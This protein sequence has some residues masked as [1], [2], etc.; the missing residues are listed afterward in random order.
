MGRAMG[1]S[2]KVLEVQEE[3]RVR[4]DSDSEI[5]SRVKNYHLES[6]GSDAEVDHPTLTYS[7]SDER[8]TSDHSAP[9]S[10]TSYKS[11]RPAVVV[12]RLRRP[13]QPGDEIKRPDDYLLYASPGGSVGPWKTRKRP[14]AREMEAESVR[15][16]EPV[17]QPA[18]LEGEG[19]ESGKDILRRLEDVIQEPAT[20]LTALPPIPAEGRQTATPAEDEVKPLDDFAPTMAPQTVARPR[21]TT[22]QKE[23]SSL[24]DNNLVYKMIQDENAKRHSAIS[25]GSVQARVV[26]PV[27]KQPKLRHTPK[28]DSLRGEVSLVGSSDS[29]HKLK[30]KWAMDHLGQSEA[31][32]ENASARRA[33]ARMEDK[34]A[35]HPPT[36]RAG[37]KRFSY[38]AMRDSAPRVTPA[39]ALGH[40][41]QLRRS[42]RHH[43]I[44]PT[45]RS[46]SDSARPL[47]MAT[48]GIAARAEGDAPSPR[49]RRCSAEH[50]LDRN[51]DVRRTSLRY[52][53][54]S[55]VSPA[56]P[57]PQRVA[58]EL[59]QVVSRGEEEGREEEGREEEVER[60]PRPPMAER[61]SRQD[62]RESSEVSF[63][64]TQHS[65]S[66]KSIDYRL[67]HPTITPMSQMSGTAMSEAELCEAKGI[68]FFPHNNTSLLLV[69]T[70]RHVSIPDFPPVPE[71][72]T[73]LDGNPIPGIGRTHF[74][75]FVTPA[76]EIGKPLYSVD[77]PLTNPRPAPEPPVIKFIPPTPKEELERPLGARSSAE[78]LR[79]EI[80][81]PRA[82]PL[83]RSLSLKDRFFRR[84]SES[85]NP[86]V[87]FGRQSSHR[88]SAPSRRTTPQAGAQKR[89][90]H[91]SSF[92]QPRDFW[93]D[94]YSDDGDFD[95]EDEDDEDYEP[96]PPG[97][98]T[99]EVP[100]E[101][102]KKM[103]NNAFSFPRAMS[104]RMPGFRGSGGFLMGN[105]LGIDRHGSNSRRHHVE[106]RA[107]ASH[108]SLRERGGGDAVPPTTMMSL[109]PRRRQSEELLRRLQSDRQRQLH[110][111]GS[112]RR[113]FTLP[114]SGG[115]RVEY[116]GFSTAAL[117]AR[118]HA[119]RRK[120]GERR[121][122]VRRERL[123]G[124]I[125]LRVFHD[126][127][128]GR[129]L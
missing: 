69:Q 114:F 22:A 39:S 28:R 2:N 124:R 19:P 60:N 12:P 31:S 20:P 27:E 111:G 107:N 119:A 128:D 125:G 85:L 92:W 13:L 89:P 66:R 104:K 49:L 10:P 53:H 81:N 67:V 18:A 123:R 90:V 75:A 24:E 65:P 5:V 129:L 57:T 26:V 97:G 6:D 77:S 50:R 94:Y 110:G 91:L 102:T 64:T 63:R 3:E 95:D 103:N 71:H 40:P 82:A 43:S 55:D 101:Q 93:A 116:V 54:E 17:F 8:S 45:P 48:S 9:V 78:E 105:S 68:P 51:Y 59:L 62:R 109:S 120:R 117:G 37:E 72:T 86:P 96:L 56:D 33:A 88:R 32:P 4:N 61:T 34:T 122:E 127:H 73:D 118:W 87:P 115:R 23:R 47:S 79:P 121:A 42:S 52:V 11:Q 126:E 106:R 108:P 113:L 84:F 36:T 76:D 14:A 30:H 38:S 80:E 21:S 112:G 44:D 15:N 29:T 46:V 25:D 70:A 100:A 99:S 98:D 35:A 83:Q 7:A 41:H 16:A 58:K 74:K 1:L